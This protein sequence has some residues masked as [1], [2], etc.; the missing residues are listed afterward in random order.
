MNN[1]RK[2]LLTGATGMIGEL[3][4]NHAI[5]DEKVGEIISLVRR[6]SQNLSPKVHEILVTDFMDYAPYAASFK[7][8]D[9]VFYCL[10]VYTGAVP[11]KTFREI[12]VDYPVRL[13]KAIHAVSPKVSFALLSGQGADPT[14][15]SKLMF[16][17]EKGAAENQLAAIGFSSFYSFRPGYIYPVRKRKEPNFS[18]V[19]FR[20]LYPA[21]KNLSDNLGLTS[22]ELAQAM[23]RVVVEKKPG[24][25][26]ENNEIKA[27]GKK[28][29]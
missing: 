5:E 25:I 20:Y 10:G 1:K 11:K 2:L 23:Y 18:Y 22:E 12:T 24:K 17:K 27:L 14:E 28:Q 26:L 13:A 9:H 3:I 16:A 7:D 21:L 29:S 4:L 8:I 6:K 19:L 15:K